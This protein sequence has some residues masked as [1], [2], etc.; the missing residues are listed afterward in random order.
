[1]PKAYSYIRFSTV[2]Q[3]K[4]DSLRR[5]IELSNN[6]ALQHNLTID[7]S[8]TLRDL[9]VSA[10]DRS[11]ITK[12]ALGKFLELVNKGKIEKGSFLLVESLDRLSRAEVLDALS[13]FLSIISAEITIVTLSDNIIY[14]QETLKD[15]YQNLILSIFI[16]S[17]ASEE[18]AIKSQRL[19][20]SWDNKR[21]TIKAK[22]LTSRCPYWLVATTDDNGFEFI[23][24]NVEVVKRILNMAKNGMGNNT[25]TKT[26]NQEGVK[27]FSKTDG[28]QPSYIQKVLRSSALYGDF[29]LKKV[30]GGSEVIVG[31]VIAD[32]YPAVISKDEWTSQNI[33]DVY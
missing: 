24:E 5:Q 12:G 18:S 25:I 10:F 29:Q 2:E 27:P 32:Y 1:M 23:Q 14:S 15:N 3:S 4:G 11:N 9:G 6:Y 16:M 13:T 33:V 8:I 7:D 19:R 30:R 28:W 21:K 17:R 22:R 31:D 26:L 20:A